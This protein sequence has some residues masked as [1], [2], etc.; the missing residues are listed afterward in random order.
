M[1]HV[2][3]L[4][5]MPRQKITGVSMPELIVFSREMRALCE[6]LFGFSGSRVNPGI[7]ESDVKTAG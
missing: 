7:R 4:E 1:H 3:N 2:R 5:S 6:E